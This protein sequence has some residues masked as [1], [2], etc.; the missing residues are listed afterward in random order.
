MVKFEFDNV[1]IKLKALQRAHYNPQFKEDNPI[2]II[3]LD[4]GFDLESVKNEVRKSVR[5]LSY[6]TSYKPLILEV[7]D[8]LHE[9]KDLFFLDRHKYISFYWSGFNLCLIELKDK[10]DTENK[11]LHVSLQKY[12]HE[13]ESLM[14]ER[15]NQRIMLFG[16][17]GSLL[18]GGILIGMAL[19]RGKR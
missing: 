13:K 9:N 7:L 17:G 4:Q 11:Q 19:I 8:V 18:I 3:K 1:E 5:L 15:K 12:K 2:E 16:F 10:D 6:E 14:Y